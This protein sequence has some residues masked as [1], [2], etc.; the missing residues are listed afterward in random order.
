MP[1]QYK[2]NEKDKAIIDDIT[3]HLTKSLPEWYGDAARLET[4]YPEIHSYRNSF[5]LRYS[6]ID[7]SA[8]RKHILV[9]IR[10]NPKMDSIWHAIASDIH[11]NV[12]IEYSSL[13]FVYNRLAGKDDDLEVIR[14]LDLIK[15]YCAIVMEEY[16]SLPLRNI[17]IEQRNA[18]NGP[19]LLT[20]VDAATKTGKWIHYFHHH[21][22]IPEEISYSNEDILREVDGYARRLERANHGRVKAQ[23]IREA[24]A[25][26]INNIQID[27]MAFSQSHADMTCD[28]V[29]Y[30]EE[31]KV[32]VIDIKRRLAPI[33]SD[34]GLIMTHPET[35]KPQIFS[36]G[37]YLPESLL[38]IYRQ[39][40]LSGYFGDEQP[41]EFI[42]HLYSAIKVLDK[43]TMY[44]ELM[45]KYKGMKQLL[46]VPVGPY[47]TAYFQNVLK[48]YLDLMESTKTRQLIKEVKPL[49]PAL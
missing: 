13:E 47:V 20:L 26:R 41:D 7:S 6:V 37:M 31:Q 25:E 22:N 21:I 4:E 29:L 8:K 14:P 39:A 9:K 2:P 23:S 38:K 36:G 12:P 35:F 18:K 40:I 1:L 48:K 19:G 11:N 45:H 24:F 17:L 27:S 3:A 5:I 43:W 32:C 42:V 44:E 46:S 33:Y 16:P 34:L 28:N 10:R 49:D 15:N 30:S